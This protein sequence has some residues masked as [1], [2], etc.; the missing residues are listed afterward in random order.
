MISLDL[1]EAYLHVSIVPQHRWFLRF[2]LRDQ[3]GFLRIYQWRVLPFGLA[4]APR[5]FTKLLAPV[6][7][8]LHL[9]NMSMC[10]YIDDIFHAQMSQEMVSATR[11]A[12]VRLHLHL[13]F[14]INLA[15]SF[16]VPSQGMVHLGAWIDTFREIV[17]PT[18]N[19][20][21]EI[22]S[23]AQELMSQGSATAAHLQSVVGLMASCHATVPLCL[24]HLRPISSLL[25]RKFKMNRDKVTKNIPLS[26]PVLEALQFWSDPSRLVEGVPLWFVPAS[27]I[28]TTDAS[29]HGWGAVLDGRKCAGT[30]THRVSLLHVN[31]LETMAVLRALQSFR[32][33]LHPGV[34]LVQTDN[35]TVISYLNKM[36]GTRS[37]SLNQLAREITRWCLSRHRYASSRPSSRCG[38]CRSRQTVP[39]SI[40][41]PDE[42]GQVSGVVPEPGGSQPALSCGGEPSVDLFATSKNAKLPV[43]YSRSAEPSAWRGDALQAG[44]SKDLLYLLPPIPLL[45]LALHKI[46][47][48]EAEVIAILPWWPRRGWFL[49]VLSL[50]V[51]LPVLLPVRSSLIKNPQHRDFPTQTSR[52]SG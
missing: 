9:G 20:V 10:P 16:L 26:P 34:L 32:R 22:S 33:L 1:K 37:H 52:P 30:W 47:R 17:M 41:P 25:K 15:K 28:L 5:L 50:L 46:R 51:Y 18:Q 48:E 6:A 12:S 21:Q 7:A 24:F 44:W 8:H 36:G 38:Q 29:N 2:A 11:D 31:L 13:G 3:R 40:D 27:Q 4:T 49:L 19:K 39:S 42:T 14:I 23:A 35:T 43:F 45:H